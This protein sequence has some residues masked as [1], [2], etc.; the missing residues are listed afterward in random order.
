MTA[1]RARGNLSLG[2]TT[3]IA[4]VQWPGGVRF[5][6]S[7]SRSRCNSFAQS[8]MQINDFRSVDLNRTGRPTPALGYWYAKHV[9]SST[10]WDRR[11]I[12]PQTHG[13]MRDGRPLLGLYCEAAPTTR[14]NW[15]GEVP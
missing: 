5:G 15:A 1:V 6:S 12:R 11:Q 2:W 13:G 8:S 7:V 4:G 9:A 14:P 10:R 3:S